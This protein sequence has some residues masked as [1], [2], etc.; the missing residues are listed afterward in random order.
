[1]SGETDPRTPIGPADRAPFSSV[2]GRRL[3]EEQIEAK[4]T[5]G[6]PSFGAHRRDNTPTAAFLAMLSC[7]LALERAWCL[8]GLQMSRSDRTSDPPIRCAWASF[9][10]LKGSP[11]GGNAEE[12]KNVKSKVVDTVTCIVH[13]T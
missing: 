9:Y 10:M 8:S 1:M 5:S 3:H 7:V 4:H 11:T 12:G 2:G 6:L 13:P